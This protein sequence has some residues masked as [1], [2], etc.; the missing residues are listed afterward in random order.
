MATYVT[1]GYF[2]TTSAASAS[3]NATGIWQTWT[4]SGTT[5]ITSGAATAWLT[6]TTAGTGDNIAGNTI[7][8]GE[9]YVDRRTAEQRVAD[10]ARWAAEREAGAR[11]A[12]AAEAVRVA[13]RDRARALLLSMLDQKQKEQL[14]RD[15]FFEVIARG[16]KR[17]YRIREGSHGNVKL[18]DDKGR[19]VVSYC[20][21]PANV[22]VEDSML[23]QK[24]QIEH[25]EVE[26]LKRANATQLRVA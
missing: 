1:V 13:A 14:Q 23:A 2:D 12:A 18:L 20:G 9:P 24:L 17:R 4:T 6:W 25:D 19:E 16:S 5:N 3:D 22:P 11:R 21:Q 15:R 8:I 26:Y 7:V 10:E